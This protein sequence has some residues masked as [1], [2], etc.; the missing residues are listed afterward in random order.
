MSDPVIISSHVRVLKPQ[1]DDPIRPTAID[2]KIDEIDPEDEPE[3]V[4]NY[5]IYTFERDGAV[6]NA[7]AYLDTIEEVSIY[8]PFAGPD[9]FNLIDAPEFKDDVLTYL[10][11]CYAAIEELREDGYHRIWE[12]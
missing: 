3:V 1:P 12:R 8:G 9:D 2:H 10:K 11:R 4:Y 7:R 5:L 6:C